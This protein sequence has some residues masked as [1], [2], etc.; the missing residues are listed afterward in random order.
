MWGQGS[1]RRRGAGGVRVTGSQYQVLLGAWREAWLFCG[2]PC[3]WPVCGSPIPHSGRE[4][5]APALTDPSLRQET[6]L[7]AAFPSRTFW[8]WRDWRRSPSR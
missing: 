3:P 5:L 2:I 7:C 1:S 8:P 4:P 6:S